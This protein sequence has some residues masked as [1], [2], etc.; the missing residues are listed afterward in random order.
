MFRRVRATAW[1]RQI[2][3]LITDAEVETEMAAP[4]LSRTPTGT[5]PRAAHTECEWKQGESRR[6]SSNVVSR[7]TGPNGRRRWRG[8][9]PNPA[10]AS[11]CDPSPLSLLLQLPERSSLSRVRFAAPT[12]RALDSSG[13]FQNQNQLGE[14]KGGYCKGKTRRTPLRE[15]RF[16]SRAP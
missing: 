2:E 1:S 7:G 15:V 10:G 9:A 6:N 5:E 4:T 8:A 16:D 3:R 14:G 11:P 13:P 12:A